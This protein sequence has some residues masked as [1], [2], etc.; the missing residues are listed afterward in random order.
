MATAGE[1]AGQHGPDGQAATRPRIKIA[2]DANIA[3]CCS[4]GGVRSATFNLGVLQALQTNPDLFDQ[5]H[6]VTAV[7]GGAYVAVAHALVSKQLSAP[8][9][10]EPPGETEPAES[11]QAAY[12]A[13][14]P[15]EQ[16]LRD[17]TRYMLE[18]WQLAVRCLAVAIRGVLINALL[19]GALIFIVAELGGALIRASWVGIL[20]GLQTAH[21]HVRLHLLWLIPAIAAVIT[22]VL[23]WLQGVLAGRP[24]AHGPWLWHKLRHAWSDQKASMWSRIFLVTA[25]GTVFLG[26]I[27]P[28][29]IKGLYTVSLGNGEWSVITRFLGFS[30]GV[31]CQNAAMRYGVMRHLVCGAPVTNHG[32]DS[33]SNGS[34]AGTWHVRAVTFS[35]FA[36][37]V[38]AL[39]RATMG[40]MRTYQA[41]LSKSGGNISRLASRTGTFLRQR[42]VPWTGSA[43]L[44]ATIMVVTLRWISLG[45]TR[46]ML[47]LPLRKADWA[48]QAAQCGYAAVAIVAIKLLTDINAVAMHRF[49]RDRLAA[50]YGVVHN[51]GGTKPD[52]LAPLSDVCRPAQ[53]LVICAAANRLPKGET[54]K[55]GRGC[56][57]FTFTPKDVGF[58]A[59][60][61]EPASPGA[62]P[63]TGPHEPVARVRTSYYEDVAGLTLFDAVAASGAA[64]SPVIGAMTK[65]AM[66]MLLAAANMRL[67]IWLPDPSSVRAKKEPSAGPAGRPRAPAGIRPPRGCRRLAPALRPLAAGHGGA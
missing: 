46:P 65:P 40:R 58:G 17:H 28:Y 59:P 56:V 10:A 7:A 31:G 12:A 4:G 42:L 57:S 6:T 22:L 63:A 30:N 36:A 2:S 33:A 25:L 55:P 19:V 27:A 62:R 15:E 29:A 3:V 1:R 23:A 20:A 48:S 43:L 44:V 53:E 16:H 52:G 37:A 32:A 61:A 49:Y 24:A 47:I 39:A 41:E 11:A 14:S 8:G 38:V 35:T 66:R 5:V 13:T 60:E 18:T 45:A 26:I 54:T 50:V 21:P 51:N 9:E 67:G 34:G 64:V